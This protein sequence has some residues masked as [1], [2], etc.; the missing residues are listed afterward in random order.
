MAAAVILILGIDKCK[1]CVS[2]NLLW[3]YYKCFFYNFIL[4]LILFLIIRDFD[5][6]ALA[7][8]ASEYRI[9]LPEF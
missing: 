7:M 8:Q 9:K 1:K 5:T 2:V 6:D 4:F 3:N